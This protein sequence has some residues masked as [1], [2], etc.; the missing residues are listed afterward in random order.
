MLRG[1][2]MQRSKSSD[3]EVGRVT[4]ESGDGPCDGCLR[5]AVVA[6]AVGAS[7]D[8]NVSLTPNIG[9]K[10]IEAYKQSRTRWSS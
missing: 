8:I 1:L 10:L 4:G 7:Y 2:Q 6:E 5:V 9:V 3:C